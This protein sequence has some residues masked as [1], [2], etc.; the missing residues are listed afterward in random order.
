MNQLGNGVARGREIVGSLLLGECGVF[1]V[2]LMVKDG[3]LESEVSG[4]DFSQNFALIVTPCPAHSSF[5]FPEAILVEK[6]SDLSL[7]MSIGSQKMSTA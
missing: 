7:L 2:T 4:L 1:G 5:V 3:I 6:D